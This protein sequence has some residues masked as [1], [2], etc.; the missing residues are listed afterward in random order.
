V[1]T[2]EENT[3]IGGFGSHVASLLQEHGHGE[4]QVDNIGIPD[5]FVEHGAQDALRSKYGL[6]ADGITRRVLKMFP[7]R[8]T[9]PSLKVKGGAGTTRR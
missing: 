3:T 8:D 5:E 9:R 4:T 1:V 7:K 6:D 2:V